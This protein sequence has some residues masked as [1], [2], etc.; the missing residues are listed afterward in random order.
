MCIRD[1][2]GADLYLKGDA[3]P[4]DD[5]GVEGLV[6]IGLGGADIVLE[7]CIRDRL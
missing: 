2:P 4:A 7:M 3:L 5:G 1:S 6:H